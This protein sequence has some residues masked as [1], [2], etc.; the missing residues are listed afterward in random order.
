MFIVQGNS[1]IGKYF[2]NSKKFK[3]DHTQK[4]KE[5]LKVSYGSYGNSM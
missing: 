1:K 4:N 2:Q 3:M 5:S